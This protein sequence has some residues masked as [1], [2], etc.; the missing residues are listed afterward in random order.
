MEIVEV[1]WTDAQEET[2]ALLPEQTQEQEGIPTKTVGFLR[3]RTASEVT[4][5][6]TCFSYGEIGEHYRSTW[7]IPMGCVKKIKRLGKA[8]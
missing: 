6:A 4:V 2:S 3:K 1:E 8:S 5:S 7:T